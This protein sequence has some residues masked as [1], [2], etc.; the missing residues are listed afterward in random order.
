MLSKHSASK[1]SRFFLGGFFTVNGL[2]IH[3]RHIN[4]YNTKVGNVCPEKEDFLPEKV[5][6]YPPQAIF[7]QEIF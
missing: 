2:P 4:A 1:M 3:F 5:I 7:L 6:Y